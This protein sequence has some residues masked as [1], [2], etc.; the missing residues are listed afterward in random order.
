MTVRIAAVVVCEIIIYVLLRQYKPE[1]AL[2][3]EAVC[4]VIL[5]FLLSDELESV[6]GL[7]D[8]LSKEAGMGR[9]TFSVLL[10]ALGTALMVQFTADLSR[11]A[12]ESA[13]ASQI[14]LAGKV[15]IAASAVPLI[16]GIIGLISDLAGGL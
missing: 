10:K 12:G 3:S 1:F 4:G 15:I 8:S 6:L 11:D 16:E 9:V 13:A 14:E 2:L 5:L 7:F